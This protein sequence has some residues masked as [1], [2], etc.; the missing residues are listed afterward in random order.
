MELGILLLLFREPP[1]CIIQ[2]LDLTERG[3]SG[4]EGGKKKGGW[5][6]G[7]GGREGGEKSLRMCLAE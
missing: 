3:K 6:G 4:R 2:C 5:G 1:R 7:K